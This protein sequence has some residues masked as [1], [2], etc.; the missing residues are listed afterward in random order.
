[1]K[2]FVRQT[3]TRQSFGSR[4]A[5]AP[6]FGFG[7]IVATG[8]SAAT[9]T[10]TNTNDAGAGSLRQA[11]LDANGAGGAD[12]IDF[13]IAGGGPH[14]IQPLSQLP[15]ITEA[16]DINGFS[17]PG[18]SAN[19]NPITMGSNAVMQIELD[20]SNAGSAHGIDID[21]GSCTIRGLVINRFDGQGI[22]IDD[23]SGANE[24]NTIAGNYIGTNVAGTADLG[25]NQDGIEVDTDNNTIGG[26]A[27]AARNVFSGNED[28]GI[29]LGNTASGNV[30]EGNF[31]GT[32]AAGTGALGNTDEGVEIDGP[33]NTVGGT[34]TAQRNI[35][36]ANGDDGIDIEENG[37]GNTVEGNF[38]GTDITCVVSLGNQDDG[39]DLDVGN[40]LIGGTD[41]GAGNVISSNG[42]DG[43]HVSPSLSGVVIQGNDIG[44]DDTGT[45]DLGNGRNGIT[46]EDGSN[47]NLIGGGAVI[48]NGVQISTVVSGVAGNVI[49]GNVNLGIDVQGA[50]STTNMILGN[51]V[52]TNGTG[53]AAIANQGGGIT[54]NGGSNNMIGGPGL[55]EGNVVSGNNS[56]GITLNNATA[57]GNWIQGNFVGTNLAGTAAIP[58]SSNGVTINSGGSNNTIGGPTASHGNLISGNDSRGVALNNCDN[59]TVQNNRIG[60]DVT[61]ASALP[62]AGDGVLIGDG[63]GNLI[64][65]GGNGSSAGNIIAFNDQPGVLVTGTAANNTISYNSIFSNAGLGIDLNADGVTPNDNQDPDLGP[66]SLQNFPVVNSAFNG[67]GVTV[68]G[69]LNSTPS[70]TFHLEFFGNDE[71]DPS[72]FGEG[73]TLLG[74]TD[75]TTNG[76]GFGTFNESFVAAVPVGNFVTATATNP[77]GATSEFS[78][79]EE[80]T[81]P[82]EPGELDHF[83]CYKARPA[84][85][86]PLFERIVVNVTDQFEEKVTVVLSPA[87]MCNPVDKDFEGINDPTAHL[88]CYDIKDEKDQESFS[89]R[90]VFVENQFGSQFLNIRKS[91]WLC[92]PSEK[93]FVSSQLLLDHFKCYAA[94]RAKDAPRFEERG[95]LLSDQFEEKDTR[96][97]RPVQVCNPA[98]KDGSGISDPSAHLVCYDIKDEKGLPH[99]ERR[100]V[101]VDNQCGLQK[102]TVWNNT[103]LCVPSTKTDVNGDPG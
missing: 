84:A 98:D 20:G 40:N 52:G 21:A 22:D 69:V 80:V 33:N 44:T 18:A 35:I 82:P 74:S 6:T 54:I 76:S 8:A 75:V 12:I 55:D 95:V 77:A 26:T 30:I 92:V 13:N 85:G 93:E 102:L 96:V 58:N 51:L 37:T 7:L 59:N 60:T 89:K 86:E 53:T 70:T 2:T 46:L 87:A 81:E 100:D 29:D 36:S 24:N 23:F 4:S 28:E 79:C 78:Q 11:I 97:V 62:N 71:C 43:I 91:E 42:R 25:N 15:I 39:V 41:L 90:D 32:N 1:M 16:V 38:I 14:T 67:A 48:P 83:K 73:Q 50:N 27:A 31:V 94:K 5:L 3:T 57:T 34:T 65:G 47:N 101:F 66:N 56:N 72:G 99:F 88:V 19:T 9:F 103:T 64:G 68:G 45:V 63:T 61:G 10:V 17:Q 49:S